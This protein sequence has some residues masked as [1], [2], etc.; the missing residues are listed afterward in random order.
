MIIL[1]N[2]LVELQT[3]TG[4]M[5]THIFRPAAPGRYRRHRLLLRDI[6]DHRADPPH[7]GDAGRSWLHC[8]RA[9]DLSRV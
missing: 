2:E 3:S 1:D 5:R 9:G 6:P 4:P 7:G 8:G